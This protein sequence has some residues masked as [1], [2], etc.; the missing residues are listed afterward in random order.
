MG[1]MS[2]R[3]LLY[4]LS[5]IPKLLQL[6]SAELELPLMVGSA[7]RMLSVLFVGAEAGVRRPHSTRRF[8]DLRLSSL[9]GSLASGHS[10][11]A[12]LAGRETILAWQVTSRAPRLIC[13]PSE[14]P[15]A[16]S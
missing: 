8:W 5:Y 13:T 11:W 3:Q 15:S 4:R 6:I 9:W 12:V 1:F 2:A 7:T 14:S 16:Q 10:E